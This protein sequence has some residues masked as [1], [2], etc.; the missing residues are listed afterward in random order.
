MYS[1]FMVVVFLGWAKSSYFSSVSVQEVGSMCVPLD[2]DISATVCNWRNS[3]QLFI[4]LCCI[5]LV[6]NLVASDMIPLS[7][8]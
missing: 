1:K 6:V 5:V 7:F 2:V 4:R 3:R 8:I